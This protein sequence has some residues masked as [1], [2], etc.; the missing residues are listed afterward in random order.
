MYGISYIEEFEGFLVDLFNKGIENPGQ[1]MVP[2]KMYEEI[3]R[4]HPKKFSIP[5]EYAIRSKISQMFEES[6]KADN[7]LVSALDINS[8]PRKRGRKS[9]L[10]NAVVSYIEEM[11]RI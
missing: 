4:K 3:R 9:K 5:A 1:K 11:I 2:G 10:P 8:S 6:K 7:G